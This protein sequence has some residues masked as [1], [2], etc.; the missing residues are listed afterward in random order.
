M[1]REGTRRLTRRLSLVSQ[2]TREFIRAARQAEDYSFKDFLHGYLYARFT[3]EYIGIGKG[4]HPLARKIAPLL[5]VWRRVF[6]PRQNHRPK[7]PSLTQASGT[8][9]DGYHGKVTPLETAKQLVAVNRPIQIEDLEQVIPYVR[10]RAI[11]QQNP[12]HIV[13][14]ECPCRTHKEN[15]CLPLDVCLVIGEPFAGFVLEHHPAKSR[16]ISQK[17][18]IQILEAEDA[19]G[20]VHHAFFKDAMMGRFYAIC[21]CCACCCGAMGAHQRGTPMLASSGYVA[22][23]DLDECIGCEICASYCQFGALEMRSGSGYVNEEKCMGCGV[24]LDKCPEGAIRLRREAGKGVP[25]EIQALMEQT[26]PGAH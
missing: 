11:V 24:C 26:A 3:Y 10:A 9:A 25:L 8:I 21:N 6:P 17:E 20:H 15:P 18:A 19:R 16:R 14:L 13:V 22:E 5:A 4:D 12:D 1:T 2:S 7:T 23:V